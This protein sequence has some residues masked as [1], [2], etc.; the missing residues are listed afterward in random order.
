[1]LVEQALRVV[2]STIKKLDCYVTDA[3]TYAQEKLHN[4]L[5]FAPSSCR[6]L[7]K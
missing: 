2:D 1:M 7:A 3:V 4:A 6:L 5:Y